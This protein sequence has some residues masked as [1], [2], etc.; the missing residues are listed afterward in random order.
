MGRPKA[1]HPKTE[2]LNLR[3]SEAEIEQLKLI[4]LQSGYDRL[5]DFARESLLSGKTAPTPRPSLTDQATAYELRKI[6]NNINQIARAYNGGMGQLTK[7]NIALLEKLWDLLHEI[8][9]KL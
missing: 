4:A 5:S 8:K 9:E 7:D 3:F 6:G 1:K 2:R